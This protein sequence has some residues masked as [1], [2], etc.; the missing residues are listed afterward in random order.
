MRLGFAAASACLI[1]AAC[2]QNP[3]EA[4]DVHVLQ[5]FVEQK[6]TCPGDVCVPAADQ[7]QVAE[8]MRITLREQR[9][10]S[11]EYDDF[12]RDLDE[13]RT[14]ARQSSELPPE[15]VA[16]LGQTIIT[17]NQ[18]MTVCALN[19]VPLAPQT[20]VVPAPE[21]PA[22]SP[23]A[24]INTQ[25]AGTGSGSPSDPC[26]QARADW[27]SLQNSDS[28][29]IL[30]IYRNNLPAACVV[31]RALADARVQQLS[32]IRTAPSPQ[33]QQPSQPRRPPTSQSQPPRNAQSP[34]PPSVVRAPELQ[35]PDTTPPTPPVQQ[36][37]PQSS[38][39]RL[40]WT[41]QPTPQMLSQ[42]Y[43]RRARL[44]VMDGTATLDCTMLASLSA[45]CRVVSERPLGYGFGEAAL[46]ASRALRV[47]PARTD[48]TPSAGVHSQ[49]RV[50]FQ[51]ETL[52]TGPTSH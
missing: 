23:P 32:Q 11:N 44:E 42:L 48:G 46:Q 22:S 10:A 47:A 6:A 41:A 12:I 26:V 38:G 43:P 51:H 34:P 28:V 31:Q 5:T 27:A 14:N 40:I 37:A 49:V 17:A 9:P 50:N 16:Q 3:L 21:P 35:R 29:A 24:A 8:C 30:R 13:A 15:R 4:R 2:G 1:L 19:I 39:G 36:A 52:T 20:Q 7:R 18:I 25:A 33:L 45:D